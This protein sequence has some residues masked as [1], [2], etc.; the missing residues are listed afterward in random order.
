[1][2]E[3]VVEALD[4]PIGLGPADRGGPVLDLLERL[5]QPVRVRPLQPRKA[6][7]QPLV[8]VGLE[9]P[10]DLVEL[11]PALAH[12]LA[13]SGHVGELLAGL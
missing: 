10:S 4:E 1:M 8:G 6:V 3:R 11:L 7:D 9:V 12:D 2:G 5:A 13:G